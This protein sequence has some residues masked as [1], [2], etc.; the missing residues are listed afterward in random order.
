MTHLPEGKKGA[1]PLGASLVAAS[2]VALAGCVPAAPP[3]M[4]RL[5]PETHVQAEYIN[6]E[7]SEMEKKYC[8]AAVIDAYNSLAAT[9]D[10]QRA[11][12]DE[13]INGRIYVIDHCYRQYAITAGTC[14]A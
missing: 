9:P 3:G 14:R 1:L 12:R 2:L 7:V 10:L 4:S 6:D 11:Y 13:V 8:A 5:A